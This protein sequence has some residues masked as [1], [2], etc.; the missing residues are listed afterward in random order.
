MERLIAKDLRIKYVAGKMVLFEID[1][2]MYA[3]ASKRIANRVL[4]GYNNLF[5][6]EESALS[7]PG[8]LRYRHGY[9]ETCNHFIAIPS[10]R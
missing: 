10:T 6:V 7:L 1:G 4:Q 9:D 2:C 3:W 8:D 5:I